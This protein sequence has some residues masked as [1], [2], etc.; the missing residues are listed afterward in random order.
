MTIAALQA[1][2]QKGQYITYSAL[3]HQVF[4][5]QLG[6]PNATADKTLLMFH[7]F[8]ESS[9]SY[10]AV[11][12]RLLEQFD[13]IV[14]FDFLGYGWSDKPLA[15]QYSYSLFEQADTAL[16]VWKALGIKGGHLLAHDMGNSVA[17]EM[18]A[19]YE[20]NLLPNWF[21]DGF[22]SVTFTNGS[23]VLELASLRIAQKILLSSGGALFSK[24]ASFPI[25]KHQ[26][27]SA[28][29]NNNLS[30][31]AIQQLWDANCLQ[32]GHRKAHLTIRYINDRKQF[33]KTRWIPALSNT[34][35]PIHIC[36]GEDD[37]V[38][39]VEMAHY[40]KKQVCTKATLSIMKGLGHFCQL[41][42]PN[43]WTNHVLH[44]Y[45]TL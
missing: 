2:K 9:F 12:D 34:N 20:Q 19:R 21:S 40:L 6:D 11:I 14:L 4:S 23:I 37:A 36:W 45:N 35:L 16:V 13:R 33:E 25:F 26:V 32:N 1:W 22:Q 15:K 24:V 31:T 7:G 29:G 42:S 44:F 38:A 5:I 18:V 39:R 27:R 41:G 43:A 30:P 28:H 10:H 3:N 17:T 8:P